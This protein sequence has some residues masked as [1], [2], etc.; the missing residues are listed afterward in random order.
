[1]FK[2]DQISIPKILPVLPLAEGS[3]GPV[4]AMPDEGEIATTARFY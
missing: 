3:A 2:T 1:M 4:R